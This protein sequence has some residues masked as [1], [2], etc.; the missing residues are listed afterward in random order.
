MYLV[1]ADALTEMLRR[2]EEHLYVFHAGNA[3]AVAAQALLLDAVT[4]RKQ[5][6]DAVLT[7]LQY[8]EDL[9]KS[10]KHVTGAHVLMSCW[11]QS[12]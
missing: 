5:K 1:G 2:V 4:D 7:A 6:P 11:Q 10:Q 3:Q 9:H 12:S 8:L